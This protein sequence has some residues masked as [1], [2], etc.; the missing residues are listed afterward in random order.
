[1]VYGIEK[2][3]LLPIVH[4]RIIVLNLDPYSGYHWTMEEKELV[5]KEGV[6]EERL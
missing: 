5:I 2:N 4:Y 3:I 6:R 1:M